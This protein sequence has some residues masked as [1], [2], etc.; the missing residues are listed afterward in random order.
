VNSRMDQLYGKAYPKDV[1][2]NLSN[3]IRALNKRIEYMD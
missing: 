2:P 1:V 3:H